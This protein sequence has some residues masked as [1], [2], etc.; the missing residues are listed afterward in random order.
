MA[1]L[2][3]PR[4]WGHRPLRRSGGRMIGGVCAALAGRFG[5]S[6][7][8]VRVIFLV[9]C[10]LPGPQFLIYLAL[11]LLLPAEKPASTTW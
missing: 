2:T 3:R 8:T 1:A 10:L 4:D 9:S 11:W 7:T 5:I 6:A